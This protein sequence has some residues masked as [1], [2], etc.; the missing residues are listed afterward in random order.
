MAIRLVGGLASLYQSQCEFEKEGPSLS[1]SGTGGKH[2]ERGGR[3]ESC[4]G[5]RLEEKNPKTFAAELGCE[6]D[7]GSAFVNDSE[8]RVQTV[9]NHIRPQAQ[10]KKMNQVSARGP[11]VS[12][13][14]P[15]LQP[16]AIS[17]NLC[18]ASK[19]CKP[20]T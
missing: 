4:K 2:T 11:G 14:F 6:F 8:K 5:R 3:L 16:T 10:V 18:M 15:V 13:F 7:S 12:R 20:R 1:V 9:K 17:I 19:P